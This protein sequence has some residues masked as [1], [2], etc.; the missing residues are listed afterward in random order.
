MSEDSKFTIASVPAD[1][2]EQLEM[3]L[4][5]YESITGKEA[6]EEEIAEC[7]AA[8]AKP[9]EE[10]SDRSATHENEE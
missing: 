9:E 4:N 5:I 2:E 8:L 1:P 10:T 6:T 3:A 7:R